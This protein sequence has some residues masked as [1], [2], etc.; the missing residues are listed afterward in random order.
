MRKRGEW[1][2]R[3]ER[4]G[5]CEVRESKGCNGKENEGWID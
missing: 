4:R 3:E 1:R 5:G 2:G